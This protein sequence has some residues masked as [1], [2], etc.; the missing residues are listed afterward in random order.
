MAIGIYFHPQAMTTEQYDESIR[1]LEQAGADN[2]PGRRYHA[3]FGPPD[4]LMV[5][6]VW[7][8]QESF[9]KFGQT[10]MPILAE[11][12]LDPGEPAIMPVHNVVVP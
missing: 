2:P 11:I 4:Q 8:D 6:D 1:R 12:G 5:F 10:L 3:C 7:D 9:Q